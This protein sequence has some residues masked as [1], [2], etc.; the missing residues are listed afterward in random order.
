MVLR[1]LFLMYVRAG[2][3]FITEKNA[4]SISMIAKA[5]RAKGRQEAFKRVMDS[6]KAFEELISYRDVVKL[7]KSSIAWPVA[8]ILNSP[9][10]DM[11]TQWPKLPPFCMPHG[12]SSIFARPVQ[13]AVC[14]GQEDAE[15]WTVDDGITQVARSVLVDDNHF[16]A[17]ATKLF[18][19]GVL[20]ETETSRV[21]PDQKRSDHQAR[22]LFLSSDSRQ[23]NDRFMRPDCGEVVK[24]YHY[25]QQKLNETHASNDCL[26]LYCKKKA[27]AEGNAW[28]QVLKAL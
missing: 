8:C 2:G 28:C 4:R 16:Y 23:N 20:Q 17:H 11:E 12:D 24:K 3:Y 25:E 10:L 26:L 15:L 1:F 6:K 5:L 27:R 18:P 19:D 7:K 14:R 13:T 22:R 9:S 21:P